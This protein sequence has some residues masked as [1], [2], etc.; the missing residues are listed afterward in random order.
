MLVC[1][2][3]YV[4]ILS[5]ALHRHE[6]MYIIARI[7]GSFANLPGEATLFRLRL[8]F[9]ISFKDSDGDE[10]KKLAVAR[11]IDETAELRVRRSRANVGRAYIDAACGA[12]DRVRVRAYDF[13]EHGS[14]PRHRT[15]RVRSTTTTSDDARHR[16]AAYRRREVWECLHLYLAVFLLTPLAPISLFRET[17]YGLYLS[18]LFLSLLH[19]SFS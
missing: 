10:R 19:H 2:L 7:E 17:R 3:H 16:D 18:S 15:L 4:C 14:L 1:L 8:P 11:S 9:Y 12:W 6:M 5:T 13:S